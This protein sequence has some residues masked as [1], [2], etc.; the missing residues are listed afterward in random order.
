MGVRVVA[1]A[2]IALLLLSGA[3]SSG[4]TPEEPAGDEP[5]EQE[6]TGEDGDTDPGAE[7]SA[8]SDALTFTT[9][10]LESMVMSPDQAPGGMKPGEPALE[11]AYG[12]G[13][14][15]ENA[16]A[17][18]YG[19]VLLRSQIFSTPS[20]LKG[21]KLPK[22]GRLG[23]YSLASSAFL[24]DDAAGAAAHFDDPTPPSKTE[25]NYKA[26]PLDGLGEQARRIE[27]MQKSNF[28][29]K[30][31][32]VRL[33]W[34]RGNARFLLGGY[35]IKPSG[36]DEDALLALAKEIDAQAQPTGE[37]PLALPPL[38][39]AGSTALTEDFSD[40]KS[41]W[42]VEEFGNLSADYAKGAWAV[43]AE[44][45]AYASSAAT[46]DKSLRKIDDVRIDFEGKVTTAQGAI[47]AICRA[48]GGSDGADRYY[49]TS[50]ST[51]GTVNIG[52]V[53]GGNDSSYVG[54][55]SVEGVKLGK[56]THKVRMDCVGDDLVRVQV[57]L[58]GQIIAEGIDASGTHATGA[59][60]I[61][62]ETLEGITEAT[63]DNF[64]VTVP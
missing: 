27:W 64:T 58:D 30:V 40:P 55:A 33:S 36:I 2:L 56:K 25:E 5:A 45:V 19:L 12:S 14:V 18:E 57:Q 10:D 17:A 49:V 13:T 22:V 32:Y 16:K 38:V 42:K 48:G 21:G 28:G 46:A 59:P 31:P 54:L 4:G 60:G 51:A 29:G 26:E 8:P 6:P 24:Y 61:Y 43:R 15:D 3:C 62:L 34:R 37:P 35:G 44:D 41:G 39:D 11:T 23:F 1:C 52:F 7:P 63:F 53:T 50:I 47:G 9:A 20:S